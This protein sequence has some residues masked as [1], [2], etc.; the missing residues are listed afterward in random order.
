MARCGQGQACLLRL[1]QHARM[2]ELT[3]SAR[4][5][6]PGPV[7]VAFAEAMFPAGE[8]L[9]APDA[10]ALATQVAGYVAG[11]PLLRGLLSLGLGWLEWR[12]LRQ[13]GSRFSRAAVAPRR[14]LLDALAPTLVSG[15]LLRLVSLPF[16]AAYV[17]DS[18]RAARM[19]VPRIQVPEQIE[20]FRWQQQITRAGELEEDQTLDADVVVIGTGAGGAAAA[21]ELASR[22]LAVVVIEEGDWHDRRHFNGDLPDMIRRLYRGFGATTALGNALIPV[23]IG[24]NVGGTTTINSGTCMRTPAPVLKRWREEFGLTDLDD[25]TLAPWFEG[26]ETM[27][28]VQ[29]AERRH[30][31]PIGSIIEQGARAL[32]LEQLHA[33]QRNAEGCD[34]QGLCQFGCPTDAKQST[35]VS[36]M[37]RALERGAFLFT[38]LRARRLLRDGQHGRGIEA[39]GRGADGRTVRLRVNA[40]ATVVAMGSLMTPRFLRDNGVRNPHLGRHLTLHPCGV[41]NAVFPETALRNGRTIPQGF[42]IQDFADEGLMFEGGTVP[43]AGHGLLNT[44]YGEQFV[45][46]TER[47]P[48]TAYFGFMIRDTSEGRVRRGPHRDLPWIS[49]HMNDTDFALFLRGIDTLARIYLAAGAEEV[50]LPG[51]R[52]LITV[53]NTR[54]LEA[55]MARRHRP[56]DFLMSAYHPLGTARLAADP[57]QGV[58]DPD[59]RVHGW[60]GLY[61]M[62]GSN[63]PTSLGANPQVTLMTLASRAAA[64]LADTLLE[65]GA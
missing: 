55:F 16:R 4:A 23:P 12:G 21:Y 18:E 15:L 61:V 1:C 34:G 57:A 22:G 47:Y 50:L 3:D 38:G 9:P 20:T 35:N 62:D 53:H 49:Y 14:A 46:F 7:S 26:V 13:L 63:P 65:Q 33:L 42:G 44:L 5:D 32:G 6:H 29:R 52:R 37:P 59:H 30:V 48:H 11:R 2:T 40:R 28:R 39:E 36:Y 60:Q 27:L 25:A 19:G 24:R 51:T 64:R 58:C 31:G 54:E 8:T 45:R 43:F 56:R 17:L 10:T 41:V